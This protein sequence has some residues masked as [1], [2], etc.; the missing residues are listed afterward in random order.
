MLNSK[1]HLF[2]LKRQKGI[3]IVPEHTFLPLATDAS[4]VKLILV[5]EDDSDIGYFIIQVIHQETSHHAI[6]HN[7]AQKALEEI[8]TH[9]PH[10][11]ILDYNLPDM[12]GLELHDQLRTFEHLKHTQ[13]ILISADDPPLAEIR[14]R[15][16]TFLHKPLEVRR[17]LTT[18]QNALA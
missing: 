2:V 14:K 17:L 5:V 8:K 13:T 10:L 7:T 18:I 3:H 12:T 15:N 16:I 1:N 6:Y 4:V 11:F 9:A